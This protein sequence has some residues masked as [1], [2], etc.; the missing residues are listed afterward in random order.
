MY[1]SIAATPGFVCEACTVRTITQRELYKG[2]RDATLLAL[3]RMRLID[4]AYK[5]APSTWVQY[6]SHLRRLLA[7]QRTFHVPVLTPLQLSCPPSS[8]AIPIMWSMQH[9][10]LQTP[11]GKDPSTRV[12]YNT[13]RGLRSATYAYHAMQSALQY[14][15][16]AIMDHSMDRFQLS[17]GSAPSD[18]LIFHHMT[19]GM[20]RRLGTSVQ[21][22][23]AITW[24]MLVY[25]MKHRHRQYRRLRAHSTPNTLHLYEIA[26]GATVEL[27]SFLGW[28][29][30]TE[31]FSLTWEDVLLL[32]PHLGP[33]M[34]LPIGIG[35]IQLFLAESKSSQTAK[36]DIV[37]AY[38]T[39]GGLCPGL[40]LSRL[41][42]ISLQLGYTNSFLFRHPNGDPWTSSFYR[43]TFL[44][45]LLLLQRAD[46]DPILSNL[47][48]ADPLTTIM[49][50][51][52]SWHSF[53]RGGRTHVSINHEASA[54]IATRDEVLEHGR[55]RHQS[56][57][58]LPL[59][60]KEWEL[61]TRLNITALCY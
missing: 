19:G 33:T 24:E 10:A 14:P 15:H 38:N 59:H 12:K 29:R 44:F 60:Y 40:W 61:P 13:A 48:G 46:G 43:Y 7:F 57:G 18:S 22:S 11:R 5:W 4:S 17:P 39:Y 25:N 8:P 27:L 55:W 41:Y 32:P 42:T 51:F 20:S 21:P 28:L 16:T 56:T 54:R 58:D 53:R 9:Y 50:A 30:G 36:A 26:A 37:I 3:E 6:K 52:W 23:K 47:P 34:G 2:A 35:M 45:P 1:P 31:C 49:T